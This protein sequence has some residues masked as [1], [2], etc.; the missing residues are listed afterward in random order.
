MPFLACLY[1][2][3]VLSGFKPA[4]VLKGAFKNSSSGIQLRKALVVL[5]FTIS[6]ALMVGTGIVYQQMDYIYTAD[7]GYSRDQVITIN[8]TGQNVTRSATLKNEL[9]QNE[10]IASAGT[11]TVR[12]GQQLGRT[13][14]FPEG[15]SNETNIITSIIVVDDTFIPTM[16]MQMAAGRNFSLDY[17][18]SLSMIINQEMMR[19]LKWDDAVGK[20]ISLQSGPNP[21]DLTAYHV[22]G[23]VKDFHFATIR[24][25]LEPM[26]MLYNRDNP[27]MAIKI[28]AGE[29]EA[30][31]AHI[32]QTWK[33]VNPGSTFEFD[34]LDE[35]FGKLYRNEQAFATMATHFTVLA[36]TIAGL[37]LFA[38]S[39]FTAEQRKKEIGIRKVLGASNGSIL[40]Q[41]SHEFILLVM[42]SFAVASAVAYLVMERWL[43]D[44]QYSIRI[45]ASVFVAAGVVALLIAMLTI[46]FQALK[47]AWSNPVDS[48]RSE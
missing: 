18:D 1:P 15:V 17:D 2:A 25:Q 12:L 24:H 46:S 16:G 28:K 23:V 32:E 42:I 11:A 38:L 22:V 9:L 8:Q 21:T 20:R 33:K 44:F 39:A 27:S 4:T 45:G 36:I 14:I 47:A 48:L 10:T 41:L 26:F 13:Q 6:I 35:Q 31:L 30:A 19:L 7:L 40:Y 43:S 3:F 29:T 34:F 5:Q 37:G